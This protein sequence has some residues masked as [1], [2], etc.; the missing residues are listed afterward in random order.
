MFPFLQTKFDMN[1]NIEQHANFNSKI[2]A[3]EEYIRG[4]MEDKVTLDGEKVRNL[5]EGFGDDLVEHL[6][7]EV[8]FTLTSYYS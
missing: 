4:V 8:N 2:A 7:D 3:F 1:R 6:H 5:V